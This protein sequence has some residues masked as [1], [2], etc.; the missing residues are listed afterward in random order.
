MLKIVY[1]IYST[2]QQMFHRKTH[3]PIPQQFIIREWKMHLFEGKCVIFL[4][5]IIQFH[6]ATICIF[7]LYFEPSKCGFLRNPRHLPKKRGFPMEHLYA[8][9]LFSDSRLEIDIIKTKCK[10]NSFS[11]TIFTYRWT[12]EQYTYKH[13]YRKIQKLV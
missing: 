7:L 12:K 8:G 5:M 13:I 3:P 2:H 6:Y 4:I 11:N 9:M 10:P 1:S